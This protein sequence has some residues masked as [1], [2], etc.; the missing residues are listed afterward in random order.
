MK[1]FNLYS[2]Q[3]FKNKLQMESTDKSNKSFEELN[4]SKNSFGINNEEFKEVLK[5]AGLS[6]ETYML[7]SSNKIY[8][9]LTDTI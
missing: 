4:Y 6:F 1:N 9:K 2:N 7:L 3:R 8:S 5:Q